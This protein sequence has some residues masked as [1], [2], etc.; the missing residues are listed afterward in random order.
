MGYALPLK[1]DMSLEEIENY[2]LS[3]LKQSV[4][5]DIGPVVQMWR[6]PGGY[7]A[8]PRLVLSYVDFLG[9]LYHGYNGLRDSRGR[10]IIAKSSYAKTFLKEVFSKVDTLYRDCSD[11]LYEMYRHGTIHLYQPKEFFDSQNRRISWYTYKGPR[12]AMLELK[13]NVGGQQRTLRIRGRHLTPLHVGNQ[14][15]ILPISIN[16]LYE[17]LRDAI[18][19]FVEMLRQNGSLVSKWNSTAQAILEPEEISMPW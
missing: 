15:W 17:D 1:P 9:S 11:L 4:I 6:G 13:I 19:K 18:D 16:C 3:D 5:D 2:L 7:F 12:Q 8:V 14:H 10:R